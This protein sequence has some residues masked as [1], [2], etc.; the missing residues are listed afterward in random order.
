MSPDCVCAE[1]LV[2][3]YYDQPETLGI[4]ALQSPE[5]VPQPYRSLLAHTN[6][7][8]VTVEKHFGGLVN[9]EVLRAELQEDSYL[10][11][12]LLR[13]EHDQVVVQYGIVKL[14]TKYV[15]EAPLQEILSQKKPL[16]R[17]LIEHNVLRKIELFDLLRVECGE[18]LARFFSVPIGTVTFGRTAILHSNNKPAIELL[19]IVRPVTPP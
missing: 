18:A 8:T 4:F 9:V 14:A 7:M 5:Q 12:I 16:G 13:T 15:D 17:V 19:E 2:S 3:L 1:S 11:E 10:R 6:H